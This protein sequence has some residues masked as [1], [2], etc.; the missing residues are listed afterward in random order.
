MTEVNRASTYR[1]VVA[2]DEPRI[3]KNVVSKIQSNSDRFHVVASVYNG[4]EALEAIRDLRP[5]VLFTDIRMPKMDGLQLIQHVT[6]EFPHIAIVI[7][8]GYND[9]EYAKGAMQYGVKDYLLKPLDAIDVEETLQRICIQ[10][11][12]RLL[13]TMRDQLRAALLKPISHSDIAFPLQNQLFHLYYIHAGHLPG[14]QF[15]QEAAEHFEQ[16]WARIEHSGVLAEQLKEFSSWWVIEPKHGFGKFIVLRTQPDSEFQ[17]HR[18]AAN[19]L[20]AMQIQIAPF[21]VTI[22]FCGRAIQADQL[23]E[24][25]QQ[26]ISEVDKQL[27]LG[28][29]AVI[30]TSKGNQGLPPRIDALTQQRLSQLILTSKKSQVHKGIRELFQQW[31]AEQRPQRWVERTL[32]HLIQLFQQHVLVS[33]DELSHLEYEMLGKIPLSS[34]LMSILESIWII[35]DAM[36]FVN[37]EKE[38]EGGLELTNRIEAYLKANFSSSITLEEISDK[39]HF[40]ATYLIKVYKK[41]KNTTPLKY[42]ISLRIEEAK[43][44]I[45]TSPEL[46]FKEIG[47]IVGYTDP[48]YFSRIFKNSTGTNLSEYKQG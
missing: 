46:S 48:N 7:V 30:T 19:L 34:N 32:Q 4:I 38:S 24:Q 33:E 12:V 40:N 39:F 14:N 23:W 28:H 1:V 29:S 44:L 2:E 26:L 35:L 25:S 5:D 27:A 20:N 6:Q 45:A 47:V 18:L 10:L 21:P 8:S 13:Q 11:D 31:Q 42:L 17:A 37:G 36:L 9:F 16:L 41:Y 15:S 43:R 22:I 3:L